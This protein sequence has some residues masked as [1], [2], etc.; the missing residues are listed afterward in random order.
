VS[1]PT[2][3][4]RYLIFDEIGGGG[5]ARVHLGRVLGAAGF[6]R[7]VA[8]KRL[9]ATNAGDAD[10]ATMLLDEARL[11]A[12]I[13]HPNVVPT[14]DVVDGG[15][16]LILVMEYVH[17]PSLGWLVRTLE[18]RGERAP[19]PIAVRIILDALAGLH[20]AHDA[21][22]E[23]GRPLDMVHRDVSPQNVLIG[24]DGVARIAD[25]GIA[26]ADGKMSLTLQGQIKGKL[27]YMA[28]EH[29]RGQG[30]DRR[31]DVFAT[32]IILWELITGRHL[33][34]MPPDGNTAKLVEQILLADIEPPSRHA[35]IPE[36]LDDVVMT[37]L[38]ADREERFSTAEA[39]ANALESVCPPATRKEVAAWIADTG[40]RLLEQRA[41]LVARVEEYSGPHDVAAL[42][43][44]ATDEPARHG[45]VRSR[46]DDVAM[47]TF[48]GEDA[49]IDPPALAKKPP[50][51]KGGILLAVALGF[52][53]AVA[54]LVV[55]TRR[56]PAHAPSLTVD[57][58]SVASV[59]RVT[60][61]SAPSDPIPVPEPSVVIATPPPPSGAAPPASRQRRTPKAPAVDCNPPYSIDSQGVRIP[62]RECLPP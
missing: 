17:G 26:Q 44:S 23:R 52:A 51:S 40:R 47:E 21:K 42:V 22:S 28:P 54:V 30:L 61:A 45:S 37:S 29:L 13:R 58:S 14:L 38:R 57:A 41:S 18:E 1:E 49:D 5:M 50:S 6:S 60:S 4:G 27:T 36:A 59:A 31:A 53:C 9:H 48:A 12:R 11:V 24:D 15:G 56:A 20:A 32:G 46:P 19:L 35:E 55:W 39:M 10:F 3:L 2:V 8:I 62:R 34:R 7:V 43:P 16:E 25:F 33:F